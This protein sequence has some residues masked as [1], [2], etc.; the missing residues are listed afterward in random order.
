MVEFVVV[1][2][3]KELLPPSK[4]RGALGC[5]FQPLCFGTA[6]RY[7]SGVEIFTGIIS[8]YA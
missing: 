7:C 2:P 3:G 8:P 4:L 6:A 5:P 1:H